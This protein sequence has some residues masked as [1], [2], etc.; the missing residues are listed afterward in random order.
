MSTDLLSQFKYLVPMNNKTIVAIISFL[1]LGG[2]LTSVQAQT[3]E[4]TG[5]VVSADDGQPLPGV[6]V[7][8]K[9]TTNIGTSTDV[10][11]KY[12]LE[13]PTDKNVLVFSYVGFQEREV[14]INGRSKINIE[15]EED[16]QQLENV[17]VV[18]Y[19]SQ[20]EE[21][22]T[23]NVSNVSGED[24]QNTTEN[25]V[26]KTLQGRT[27]GVQVT[28]GSG[29]LG[30]GISVQIRG[31][32]SISAGNQPLYVIDG[33][34]VTSQ[35]L[36]STGDP[37][38]N[39]I[40]SLD[41]SNVESI[42]V[43]K[44]AS[45]AAIY[46]SRASNGVVIINTKTGQEGE[47]NFNASYQVSSS[48]PTN[49]LDFLNAEQYVDYFRRAAIGGGEYDY[50]MN[51]GAWNSEQEA[52]DYYLTQF[53]EPTMNSVSEGNDWQNN[54]TNYNWQDQAFQDAISHS[55]EFSASGGNEKTTFM[56]SGA[57]S[58][59]EGIMLDNTFNKFSGR[60]NLNHEATDKLDL[61]LRVNINRT[62]NDRLPA[63]SGFGTPMQTIAQAPI[64]PIYADTDP[65][66][67]GYQK[68]DTYNTNTLYPNNVDIV[69]NSDF[70]ARIF[71]TLT[72]VNAD[73]E[74]LPNL[75]F[76]SRFA[77][78]LINQ[79]E[80]R[81]SEPRLSYFTGAAGTGYNAWTEVQNYTNDNI[82]TYQNTFQEQHDLEVVLGTSY[83][84]VMQSFTSTAG[85]NFPSKNF[86]NI[87]NAA[88][89][90]SGSSSDTK[91]RFMSYFTRA[92]YS[93]NDRYLLSLSARTDGSSRFGK[94]N[95]YGF[96]PAGSVGW[97]VTNEEFMQDV[98]MIS[99]LKL[100]ASYGVTGNAEIDN[101][102]SVGLFEGISYSGNSALTPTQT[103][104]PDL[105]WETTNQ[106]N[107]GVEYGFFEDRIN[108]SLD[109]YHKN[110]TDLLLAV[111]VP[112][113]S[114]YA[115]QLRNVGEL[116]NKG[117]EFV[118][119]STNIT[120][121]FSWSSSF[122]IAFNR[123]KITNLNGQVLTVQSYANRY[124]NRALEGEPI[125]V[126]YTNEYA[127]VNPANGDAL[128]YLNHDP[129]QQ[130]ISN[131]TAFKVDG[132]FGDRY[133]TRDVNQATR[134]VVGNPNPDFTGGFNNTF[135]Y[136]GVS[137]SVL[138]QF[139]Y[140][141]QI[142]NA[143]YF[144]RASGKY[145]DNQLV[146][147]LDAWQEP[148]DIT[149]VPEARLYGNNGVAPKSSKKL[150]DGSYLRL[151]NLKLTYQL[152]NQ[153][154]SKIDLRSMEVFVTGTN[155]LTFTEYDG[156][157]PEISLNFAQSNLNIGNTFYTAPQA[158]TI[159]AGLNIG[160]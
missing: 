93:Y 74:I 56:T 49:K 15:L 155:L 62:L 77:M 105:K 154:L 54:P 133:V 4:I 30:E 7:V 32:S 80:E 102:P 120:G 24:I 89:I 136:K 122:N 61:G 3:Q 42:S 86:R 55:F 34:P 19:G 53:Y 117:L 33:V 95:R 138:W 111:D 17:V 38:S 18:G 156:Y 140:G 131:G 99:F 128:F 8:V 22:V 29:T 39:P 46:G 118:V 134:K 9:D 153:F 10:D 109:V 23:G 94:N 151:K 159:S 79:N 68:G 63:S 40:A 152:P 119:N 115:T 129:S 113:T 75:S 148:G 65:N 60:L 130:E 44:D 45:A 96:F 2:V 5:T 123:N 59:K 57:Y 143:N 43:L 69:K 67:P 126:F 124:V 110:T 35:S 103:P 85:E 116:E 139:V 28:S 145:F 13:V 137:L 132:M 98:E 82:F 135:S 16:V 147:Q 58:D 142:Y 101:F 91:Y 47:T 27:A 26:E 97:I 104:N 121:A 71:H 50:R 106:L 36:S 12:T 11:G 51:P 88:T 48:V 83:N 157:D 76:K 100:K 41:M 127:G 87:E 150:S 66:Q 92:N 52:V 21:N 114:G 64:S 20:I 112:G 144:S 37:K 14:M 31:S 25:S 90:T 158:K 78:D 72:N 6:T 108:G 141:N 70:R 149:D 160:F 73:Y 146:S 1:F 81:Y 84:W 107:I 125:G